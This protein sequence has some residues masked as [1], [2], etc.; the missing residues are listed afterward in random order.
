MGWWQLRGGGGYAS[1]LMCCA[2]FLLTQQKKK[3]EEGEKGAMTVG[4]Q[5][6]AGGKAG[7]GGVINKHSG[8]EI[9]EEPRAQ[10]MM[11]VLSGCKNL[12]PCTLPHQGCN[13]PFDANE[14]RTRQ[15]IAEFAAWTWRI[16]GLALS[17]PHGEKNN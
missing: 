10:G 3:E 17:F 9:L 5:K 6:E 14:L 16:T 13:F 8:K 11:S 1:G 15:N 2:H 7:K 4:Q 12:S